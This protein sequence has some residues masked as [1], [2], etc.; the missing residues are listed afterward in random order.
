MSGEQN[1]PE[2]IHSELGAS[3]ASRWM[4]CP[5]SIRLSREVPRGNGGSVY[6]QEGTRAHAVAELCLSKNVEPDVYGGL[7]IEGGVVDDDMVEFVRI[8]VDHCRN[9]QH[10][11]SVTWVEKKFNLAALNPPGA[12]Y[13][14]ADFVAYDKISKTLYVADLKYG[15]GV[16]VE[17]KGNKQLRYYALGAVIALGDEYPIENVVMTIVQPRVSHPDGVV[18]SDT[19]PYAELIEFAAEL[20]DAARETLKPD[21]KLSAGSHCRFCPASGVCPEQRSHALAV[22]QSEF[23]VVVDAEFV[24]P[25][26]ETIPPQQFSEMLG[27]LHVLDDWM[28]AMRATATAKLER[29]EDVPGF[30][31]VAKRATRKWTDEDAV[32]Q[33]LK[34]EK[35]EPDEIYEPRDLKSVAQIE[36]LVGKKA[37]ASSKMAGAVAKVSS[38]YNLAPA[39]DPR[40]AV[41]LLTPSEEFARLDAG[42][43][44]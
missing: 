7:E 21:A 26:P 6:A 18:R 42:E 38:G 4:N 34:A 3:V 22:V 33:L 10:E 44:E 37:F 32:E 5:G 28:K 13:G 23:E 12:M 39:H 25:A 35:Y 30:K 29:G 8:F 43:D 24:P 16:V 14:T 11:C 27:Q 36:K 41:T 31:L 1:V 9:L 40:P 17:V 15:A 2:K 20:M 19:I